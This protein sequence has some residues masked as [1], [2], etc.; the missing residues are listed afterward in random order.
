MKRNAFAEKKVRYSKAFLGPISVRVREAAAQ[1]L[2]DRE[3]RLLDLGCGNGLFFGEIGN[4]RLVFYGLDRSRELIEEAMFLKE[5]HKMGP[6]HLVRGDLSRLCF[7]AEVFDFVTCLNTTVNLEGIAAIE[8]LL[9]ECRIL[10]K[11]SSRVL[12]DI[13]N[14][15]N[16]LMRLKYFIHSHFGDFPTKAYSPGKIEDVLAGMGLEIEERKRIRLKWVPMS[17]AYLLI[18]KKK[19]NEK[20]NPFHRCSH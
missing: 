12:V 16:P 1:Y 17:V 10:L 6:V 8:Q 2:Y 13:R 7:K 11:D 5:K 18:I 20:N 19:T 4:E 3:G 9:K 15:W 14:I